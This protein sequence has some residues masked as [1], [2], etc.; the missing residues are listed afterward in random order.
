MC[1][2]WTRAKRRQANWAA[3]PT[4]FVLESFSPS[5]VSCERRGAV[6]KG[7]GCHVRTV[8]GELHADTSYSAGMLSGELKWVPCVCPD[9]HFQSC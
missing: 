1:Y 8:R 9:L 3:A 4:I 6:G 5:C 7:G 2:R